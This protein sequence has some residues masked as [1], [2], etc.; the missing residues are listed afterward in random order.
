VSGTTSAD[1]GG[2]Y[3]GSAATLDPYIVDSLPLVRIA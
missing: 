2:T 1:G 3:T